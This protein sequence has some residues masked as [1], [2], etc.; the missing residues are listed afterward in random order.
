MNSVGFTFVLM[1]T[2]LVHVLLKR[3]L[4]WA[5]SK[6]SCNLV[7]KSSFILIN[8]VELGGKKW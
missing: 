8:N 4:D 1:M 2:I 3:F 6:N 7:L 5:L